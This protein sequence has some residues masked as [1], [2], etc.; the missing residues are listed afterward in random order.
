[1]GIGW[2]ASKKFHTDMIGT[3]P[4]EP[5]QEL[6]APTVERIIRVLAWKLAVAEHDARAKR[7]TIPRDGLPDADDVAVYSRLIRKAEEAFS[8]ISDVRG[9]TPREGIY[10]CPISVERMNRIIRRAREIAAE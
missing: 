1:M 7:P 8:F 6:H 3:V 5:P 10:A 9:I 2:D 4:Y